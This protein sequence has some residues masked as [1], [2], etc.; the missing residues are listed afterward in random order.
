MVAE[1]AVHL[2]IANPN[3]LGPREYKI[4]DGQLEVEAVLWWDLG[5]FN[6]ELASRAF[7]VLSTPLVEMGS[8]HSSTLWL[9]YCST[10]RHN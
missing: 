3:W 9:L 10:S 8:K 2:K 5:V 6:H 1:D 7:D 4:L